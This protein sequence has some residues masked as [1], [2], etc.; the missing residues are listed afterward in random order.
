[1]TDLNELLDEYKAKLEIAKGDDVQAYREM[2]RKTEAAIAKEK[3][4]K[5]AARA[6]KAAK[7]EEPAAEA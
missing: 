3:A 2:I 7:V 4:E 6:P 5:K 1:M